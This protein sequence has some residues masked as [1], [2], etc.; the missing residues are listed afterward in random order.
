MEPFRY[1]APGL[2]VAAQL[3]PADMA[4]AA[5]DG[6]TSV[7]NNRPDNEEHGQPVTASMRAAAEAA[8]LEY[9]DL[10]V[11]AGDLTDENVAGFE[12][13]TK[14]FTGPVLLFC[15]SGTR[16]THLWALQQA[17]SGQQAVGQIV[18]AA[19]QAGY[20]LESLV[21]RMQNNPFA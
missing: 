8:G 12:Q 10:P 20:D 11:V 18:A 1:L 9:H 3:Q 15:R 16:C 7:I 2:A 6:F 14:S 21:P 17:W 19:A 4:R 5:A 13:L